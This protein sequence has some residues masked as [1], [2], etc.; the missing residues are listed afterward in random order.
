MSA[1]DV[2]A[3]RS[4]G[5]VAG[6]WFTPSF[7]D[8]PDRPVRSSRRLSETCHGFG[9]GLDDD[10]DPGPRAPLRSAAMRPGDVIGHLRLERTLGSGAF[11]TV[12][13]ATDELLDDEVAIKVLADNWAGNPDVR[14]RFVEEAKILRRIDHERIVRVFSVDDPPDGQPSF[15]MSYADRGS[16]DD[17]LASRRSDDDRF[18]PAQA[19]ALMAELLA[20]LQVVHDFGVIHRDL[21]PSNVLFRSPRRHDARTDQLGAAVLPGPMLLADFGLAKDLVAR[22]GFTAAAGTPAYMA[23]EQAYTTSTLDERA[24]VY[25]ATAILAELLT[26]APASTAT[27][28][29]EAR[30]RS[31]VAPRLDDVAAD[32][33][34]L[35][36]WQAVLDRGMAAHPD[37]R[38]TSASE[39]AGAI[40][41]IVAAS[42]VEHDRPERVDE[43]S[44]LRARVAGLLDRFQAEYSTDI[45]VRLAG[46][47]R[48]GLVGDAGSRDGDVADGSANATTA[49]RRVIE[50]AGEAGFEVVEAPAGDARLDAVDLV[51]SGET[52]HPAFQGRHGPV[53]SVEV[54]ATPDTPASTDSVDR[55]AQV[56]EALRLLGDHADVIVASAA[57]DRLDDEVRFAGSAAMSASWMAIADDVEQLRMDLP[58]L[59]DVAAARSIVAGRAALHPVRRAVALR[60]LLGGELGDRDAIGRLVE[61]WRRHV[62]SGEVAFTA[63]GVASAVVRALERR[64]VAASL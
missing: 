13:L 46:P 61:D 18:T 29:D 56:V 62:S 34:D 48:V 24:D 23:P 7:D 63:R 57:L 4:S 10:A 11:A 38:F 28:L 54:G 19:A 6:W 53:W 30:Q 25:A 8:G 45:D 41:V 33:D 36:R 16:L 31:T 5:V 39:L 42:S 59:D 3:A 22:S 2:W 47:L 20:G 12:W 14:Q 44:P 1:E 15:V 49:R 37:D 52:G 26:G 17:L 40:A 55:D 9:R 60:A 43:L 64:W 27:T 32:L 35:E 50:L 21:K 51:V 58:Q